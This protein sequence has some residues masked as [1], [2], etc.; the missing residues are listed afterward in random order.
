[1]DPGTPLS[2]SFSFWVHATTTGVAVFR[3]KPSM[4]H[5]KR[6]TELQRGTHRVKKG[7]T[8]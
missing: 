7:S 1:M 4:E 8:G 6:W 2:L 3:D 5:F